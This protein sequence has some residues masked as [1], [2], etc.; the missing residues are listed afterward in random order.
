MSLLDDLTARSKRNAALI[1][2]LLFLKAEEL[3]RFL[4]VLELW[5]GHH[6]EL[7]FAGRGYV[8]LLLPGQQAY[9][10]AHPL[11]LLED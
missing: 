9:E 7:F 10:E 6:T 2:F 1:D 8:E 4:T 3:E 5:E 11:D